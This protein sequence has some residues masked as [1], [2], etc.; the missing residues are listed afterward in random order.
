MTAAVTITMKSSGTVS[1]NNSAS[2]EWQNLTGGNTLGEYTTCLIGVEFDGAVTPSTYTGTITLH[3]T[4]TSLACYSDS[5]SESCS[6]PSPPF[7][8]TS[9]PSL[10]DTNPSTS[11]GYAYDL[12][13]PGVMG[14]TVTANTTHRLRINFEEYAV[15][16]AGNQ[17]S[18]NFNWFAAVSCTA[19]SSG[20]VSFATDASNDNQVGSGTTNTSWNLQ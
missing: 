15:D 3:R 1:A 4:V 9:D 7:D 6:E 18:P 13:G 17:V 11:G 10:L 19:N 16:S 20:V 5:T 2:T 14:L 12:D 8:D